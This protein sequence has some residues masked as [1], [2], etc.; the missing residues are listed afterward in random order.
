LFFKKK[1]DAVSAHVHEK[2]E[3]MNA[4]W[5]YLRVAARL[6]DWPWPCNNTRQSRSRV[7]ARFG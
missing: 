2:Y 6:T 7:R 3:E 1:R 4:N 5:I